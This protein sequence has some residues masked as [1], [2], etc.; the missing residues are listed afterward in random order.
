[1]QHER[2]VGSAMSRLARPG[3]GIGPG[4]WGVGRGRC[5]LKC[6]RNYKKRR[7]SGIKT[8]MYLA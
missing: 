1:M 4:G 3:K 8:Y 6:E 2:R 5:R 7:G